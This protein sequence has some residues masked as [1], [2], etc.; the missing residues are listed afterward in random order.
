M[1]ISGLAQAV[2]DGGLADAVQSFA[3][4][5]RFEL[6]RMQGQLWGLAQSLATAEHELSFTDAHL[7]KVVASGPVV[8]CS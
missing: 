4:V 1:E 2:G 6:L 8:G 3:R 7:A 5:W